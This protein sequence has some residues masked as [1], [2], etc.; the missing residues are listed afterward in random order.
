MTNPFDE[1]N[2]RLSNIESLLLNLSN[3]EKDSKRNE[4]PDSDVI[5]TV[6]ETAKFLHLTIPTI[7]SMIRNQQIPVMK[8]N[9]RC[10]FRKDDII[11]YL[12]KGR[13]KGFD[14][15]SAEAKRHNNKKG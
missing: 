1:L 8:Q 7:Y 10:Y 14:E 2:A 3:P 13:Q 12:M 4:S 11:D 9:R 5:L 15:L 6:E